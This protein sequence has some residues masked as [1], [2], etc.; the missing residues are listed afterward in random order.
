MIASDR[1]RFEAAHRL[2]G[3]VSEWGQLMREGRSSAAASIGARITDAINEL[4]ASRSDAEPQ[5]PADAELDA[6]VRA[7]RDCNVDED[8]SALAMCN[9][10]DAIQAMRQR[11]DGWK[12]VGMDLVHEK[13]RAEAAERELAELRKAMTLY[14]EGPADYSDDWPLTDRLRAFIP[15]DARH[16]KI[17]L[18]Y[19]LSEASDALAELRADLT[20]EREKVAILNYG[21]VKPKFEREGWQWVPKEPT[22][23]MMQAAFRCGNDVPDWLR[24][25]YKAA[26]EFS[27]RA[28]LAQAELDAAP[29]WS[30]M[31]YAPRDGTEV[32]LLIEHLEWWTA[33][34]HGKGDGY[35]LVCR[36]KWIDFNGGGWTWS[37]TAGNPIGWRAAIRALAKDSAR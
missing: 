20:R 18:E 14:R 26:I 6:L 23:E 16:G 4:A 29:E 7:L 15:A 13:R 30:A 2:M 27:L 10:A 5:V 12:R 3:M 37:G 19:V 17:E 31:L 25:R 36:G 11:V 9:G 33:N 1:E 34:K 24:T 28:A 35:R 22:E 21:A 8:P 32:D